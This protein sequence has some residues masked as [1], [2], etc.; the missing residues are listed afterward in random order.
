MDDEDVRRGRSSR[1]VVRRLFE[2][3]KAAQESKAAEHAAQTQEL[4]RMTTELL[5]K[6]EQV[7]QT[8]EASATGDEERD[9][10]ASS[11]P[12]EDPSS[13]SEGAVSVE[14]GPRGDQPCE[15]GHDLDYGL[16]GE[17]TS[18]SDGHQQYVVMPKMVPPVLKD[19][20]GFLEFR[21]QV[22]VYEKYYRFDQ[23]FASDPNVDVGSNDRPY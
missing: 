22:M 10:S 20:G 1:E 14:V 16:N 4:M 17:S 2:E 3:Q 11:T 5:G 9:A 6:K 15:S 8:Q 12:R 18:T 19:R 21:E 23:V 7:G 13:T